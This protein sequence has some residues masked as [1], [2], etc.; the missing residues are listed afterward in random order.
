MHNNFVSLCYTVVT[1]YQKTCIKKPFD[2]YYIR[3]SSAIP[4]NYMYIYVCE[5]ICKMIC[6][7]VC[8]NIYIYIL[9]N[10]YKLLH[11][12]VK[13]LSRLHFKKTLKDQP[14]A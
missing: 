7:Y 9:T 4:L 3:F 13:I 11:R 5:T 14:E 8:M 1:Y 12:K 6:V 2:K 10:F